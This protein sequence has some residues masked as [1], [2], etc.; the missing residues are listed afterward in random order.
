MALIVSRRLAN[1]DD[2]AKPEITVRQS[3]RW[4]R[5]ADDS[6]RR[7]EQ[8]LPARWAIL[9]C[10][11]PSISIPP[12]FVSL[13]LLRTLLPHNSM[14]G[15]GLPEHSQAYL[16]AATGTIVRINMS[17]ARQRRTKVCIAE[18][19]IVIAPVGSTEIRFIAIKPMPES[20]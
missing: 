12:S 1:S 3:S 17:S 11:L 7:G 19:R 8:T 15:L 2:T 18:N 10:P 14:V 9:R 5:F 20:R 4:L 16:K 6:F 13:S